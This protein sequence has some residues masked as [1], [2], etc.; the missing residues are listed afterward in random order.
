MSA[1]DWRRPGVVI[2]CGGIILMLSLGTRQSF[3][4]FLQPMSSDL[5]WGRETFAFAIA[6]QNL[7]WGA[8]QPFAGMVADRYGAPRVAALAGA[9]YA[10]GLVL[11]AH[12]STGLALDFSA[13][14][15]IGVGLS[16]TAFGVVMGV[17]GRA[18]APHRRGFALGLVGA[19]GSFGQFAM[20]PYGQFLIAEFGWFAAL[21]AL[22]A[23]AFLIVPLAAGLAAAPAAGSSR[24]LSLRQALAEAAAHRGFW[25]LTLSFFVCGFQTIFIMVH[26]PAYLVDKGLSPAAGMTA[27][28]LV[29]F[30][31][32]VGSWGCG[33]LGDRYSKK[34]L[35][36]AIYFVRAVSLALFLLLPVSTW[37]TWIF[38][39]SF[40][41][42]WLGTVPLTNGLVAQIFGVQ[43]LATLF[44]ITFFG[45]QLG[46]FL[47][48]WAGGW[49]YDA[50][51]SYLPVWLVCLGAS[52]VAALLCLPIDERELASA[53]PAKGMVTP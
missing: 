12:A 14:L 33:A 8:M 24:G 18:V 51:G 30:F 37:S 40:G 32:I 23:T 17:V 25:L 9:C 4:L 50:T 48:A 3:G 35:L 7:A 22:A 29:M 10:A 5:G 21:L 31:N 38:A 45:H 28:A 1:T 34:Y 52:L 20:L 2:A 46:S 13:G 36:S 27:L 19:G 11:M 53:P 49:V 15:L 41:L 42:T 43:Y 47:G 44:S 39:V 26:L 16:G 6:L